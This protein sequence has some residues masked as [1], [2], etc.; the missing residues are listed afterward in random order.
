[1]GEFVARGMQMLPVVGGS[2]PMPGHRYSSRSFAVAYMLLNWLALV[3][4]LHSVWALV[5]DFHGTVWAHFG[6][7]LAAVIAW[8]TFRDHYYHPWSFWEAGFYALGMRLAISRHHGAFLALCVP[9]ALTRETTA[10]LPFAFAVFRWITLRRVEAAAV[11]AMAIWA[12]VFVP[13]RLAVGFEAPPP[14]YFVELWRRNM[15]A[16]N[17]SVFLNVVLLGPLWIYAVRGFRAAPDVVRAFA[18]ATVVYACFLA[19]VTFWWEI[20]YW[21]TAIPALVPLIIESAKQDLK[22]PLLRD[23]VEL[24]LGSPVGEVGAGVGA[25]AFLARQRA[26]GD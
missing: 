20:R 11:G 1:M 24:E 5:A 13:L 14:N 4:L 15:D 9:A 22:V 10:F 23:R 19:T 16:L 25:A 26:A 2:S 18:L 6:I 3:L 8:F 21:M 17:Y 7:T 12:I